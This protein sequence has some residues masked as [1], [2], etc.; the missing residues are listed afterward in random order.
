MQNFHKVVNVFSE[1]VRCF[2]IRLDQNGNSKDSSVVV[3]QTCHNVAKL[4]LCPEIVESW[5]FDEYHTE[6]LQQLGD[7]SQL[8]VLEV[9]NQTR[10]LLIFALYWLFDSPNF[11]FLQYDSSDR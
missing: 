10:I 4:L 3:W 5:L 8:F 1:L 11:I 9:H 2:Y 6:I 7:N